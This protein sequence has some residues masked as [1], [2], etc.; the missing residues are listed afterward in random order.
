MRRWARLLAGTLTLALAVAG[1]AA[2]EASGPTDEG[3]TLKPVKYA[4]L[5]KLVRG[6]K[7]KVV[8]LDV[9]AEY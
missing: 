4:D 9:W 6:L 2:P 7:G 8:V 1:T 5:C 3:V